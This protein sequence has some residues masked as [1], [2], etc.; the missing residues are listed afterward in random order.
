MAARLATE[1]DFTPGTRIRYPRG[2]W[3]TIIR[4]ETIRER[5]LFA[6]VWDDAWGGENGS[7]DLSKWIAC[8]YLGRVTVDNDNDPNPDIHE[9]WVA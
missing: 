7:V 2:S 4:V 5:G 3:G 1:D 9:L 6:K 8:R